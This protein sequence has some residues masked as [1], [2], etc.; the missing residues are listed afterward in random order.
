MPTLSR[1]RRRSLLFSSHRAKANMPPEGGKGLLPVLLVEMN[2]DLS[3]R[4]GP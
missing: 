3:V 4:A 2:D 1:A